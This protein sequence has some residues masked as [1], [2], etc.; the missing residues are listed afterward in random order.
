MRPFGPGSDLR[1]GGGSGSAG[2]HMA[3][4]GGKRRRA[5]ISGRSTHERPG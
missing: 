2:F 3:D 4:A 5:G 1:G